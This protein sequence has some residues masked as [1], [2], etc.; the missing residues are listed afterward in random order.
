MRRQVRER[1]VAVL[2]HAEVDLRDRVAPEAVDDVDQ[3]TQLDT[4][5]FDE[6]EHFERLAPAR[7]LAAER[8]HDV[9][10]LREQQREQ[11][12]GD[13]L[14]HAAAARRLSVVGAVV[15]GLDEHDV[16]PA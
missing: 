3:Q 2:A 12:A 10:E 13:Q 5:T 15:V 8:L 14:G 7:V 6:R 1:P 4:P 9:G 11:R 16:G